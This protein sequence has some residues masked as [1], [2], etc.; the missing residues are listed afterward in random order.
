VL[1]EALSALFTVGSSLGITP[2]LGLASKLLLCS[3]MLLGRVGI[4]SLLVGF[5]GHRRNAPVSYPTDNIIIN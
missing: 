5:I 3:A 4:L 2:E 1:F